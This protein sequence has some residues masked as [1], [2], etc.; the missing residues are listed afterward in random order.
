MPTAPRPRHHEPGDEP[1]ELG[2]L[3]ALV[4]R[5][6]AASLRLPP[7]RDRTAPAPPSLRTE[8]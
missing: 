1:S 8:T 5:V 3:R 2:D 6:F 7:A 4:A